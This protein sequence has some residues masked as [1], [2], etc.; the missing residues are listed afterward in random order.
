MV[1]LVTQGF[2]GRQKPEVKGIELRLMHERV[3]MPGEV[4]KY[5]VHYGWITAG[6]ATLQI[7]N[8]LVD[9]NDHPCYKVDIIG[10]SVGAFN[11]IVH[12]RNVWSSYM[13]T[14]SI[15]PIRAQRDISENRYRLQEDLN[16][17]YTRRIVS[18]KRSEARDTSF[19]IPSTIFDVVSGYYFLRKIDFSVLEPGTVVA[20]DAFFD[21]QQYKF[22]V[23]YVGKEIIKTNFGRVPCL[24]LCPIMP[25][26]S[27][28][29][30]ENAVRLWMSAD[31]NRV[32][33][34]CSAQLVVGSVDIDLTDYE[35]TRSSIATVGRK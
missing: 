21:N 2:L 7:A 11:S 5:R 25:F 4:L 32:P 9:Q 22:K 15:K 27:L 33:V 14:A 35:G 26:N 1:M 10:R 24:L 6:E 8:R 23:R 18:V 16:F 20:L 30:G 12:I 28:F 29:E 3:F 17:D 31:G 13:D 34:K 19:R